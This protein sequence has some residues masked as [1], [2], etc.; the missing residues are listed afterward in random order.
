LRA[1]QA[2]KKTTS[3][4]TSTSKPAQTFCAAQLAL[5]RENW[6]TCAIKCC[7]NSLNLCCCVFWPGLSTAGTAS[8]DWPRCCSF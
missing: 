4:W 5:V 1:A 3:K 6:N 8:S 2:S 7:W